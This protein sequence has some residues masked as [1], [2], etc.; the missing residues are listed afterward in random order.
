MATTIF[1]T[2]GARS[3][4]SKLAE[5]ATQR[6]GAPLAYIATGSAGDG[7]MT[8]RIARHRARRGPDWTT[9]EEPM[10]LPAAIRQA[11]G[12]FNAILVDCLTLWITNLLLDYESTFPK[13]DVAGMILADVRSFV[14]ACRQVSV[15]VVIVSNEVGMGIVP[16]NALARKFR[17]LAGE[18]NELV[19]AA[20]DEVYVMFSGVPL[21]LKG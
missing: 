10:R 6:F 1:I 3:G 20:A 21:K 7:E 19:A 18:A 5:E 2:G 12:R 8:A 16:D 9:I 11:G 13:D 14:E 17:D 4:K 15:P